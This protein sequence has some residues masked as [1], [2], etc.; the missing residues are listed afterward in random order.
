MLTLGALR[1]LGRL[2][3]LGLP[4][5]A[6]WH[7]TLRLL[8][9]AASLLQPALDALALKLLDVR[10]LLLDVVHHARHVVALH[11]LLPLLAHAPQQI[12]QT[13]VPL[14]VA[15]HEAALHHALQRAAQ[16]AVLQEVVGER[17]QDLLGVQVI[18]P[19]RAIPARI[20]VSLARAEESVKHALL[21]L[22]G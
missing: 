12:L 8:L 20:A 22:V 9:L 14:A 10:Q 4:L 11:A 5:L 13:H 17:V 16:V 1:P 2:S 3:P 7:I 19:L 21:H 18:Q 15:V 6:R